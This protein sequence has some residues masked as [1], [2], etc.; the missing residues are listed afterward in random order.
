MA[1]FAEL[2]NNNVVLRVLVVSNDDITDTSGQEQETLGVAFLQ[3]LFGADTTWVQTSYN[4]NMRGK[5]AGIGDTYDPKADVFVAPT[6]EEDAVLV[7]ARN[8]DGTFVADDP[9][10]PEVNEAWVPAE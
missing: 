7:R 10:T 9:S 5:Y 1:H 2:D 8:P 6:A 3:G 4:G